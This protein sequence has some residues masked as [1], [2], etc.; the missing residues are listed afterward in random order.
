MNTYQ[1]YSLLKINT[2]VIKFKCEERRQ[3]KKPAEQKNRKTQ[4]QKMKQHHGPS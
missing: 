1:I 3:K 4:T 2:R